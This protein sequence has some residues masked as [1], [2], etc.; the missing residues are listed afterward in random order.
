M[1]FSCVLTTHNTRICYVMLCYASLLCG[2]TVGYPSDSLASC[3][4][5]VT[6]LRNWCIKRFCTCA[7][8]TKASRYIWYR[9]I[10]L[11]SA[12][13]RGVRLKVEI[14]QIHQIHQNLRNPVSVL[15][16]FH[17]LQQN[18]LTWNENYLNPTYAATKL[19][20]STKYSIAYEIHAFA[21]IQ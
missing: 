9:D 21:C 7:I 12:S 1:L 16:K 10:S 11:P 5:C 2:S 3:S 13:T 15:S 14:H 6:K 8:S 20:D 18:P 4:N 19:T 17:A